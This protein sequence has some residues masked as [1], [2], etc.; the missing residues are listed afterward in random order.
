MSDPIIV[1]G[2]GPV[3]LT[4]AGELARR[5]VPVRIF[6][7]LPAPTTESRAILVHARSLEMFE[8]IGL[9]DEI[10]AAG[11]RTDAMEMHAGKHSTARIELG[12][13]DSSF[14]Y[15]ITIAQTETERI[16]TEALAGHGV[17]V[18]RGMTLTG[19]E[20]DETGVRAT[21]S[22]ADGNSE[23]VA[24]AW[25]VGTDGARSE[26]RRL[27]GS[28][29]AGSF[30]GE[31]FLM[32]DVHAAHDFDQHTMYTFFSP[33]DG[34]LMVFPMKGDRAR[35]IAQIPTTA[36]GSATQEWLQQVADD[37]SGERIK[38]HDS[39]WLTTFEI[40]HAQV[41]QYRYGRVFLAGDAAHIHS[42]AGG[43]GMNT[44]MQDAFNLG[45][46]LAA[47]SSGT[48]GSALLDSYN[49]ER[50]PVGAKVIE[51]ATDLMRIATLSNPV[52]QKVRNGAMHAL[53]VLA[54]VRQAMADKTEETALSYRDSPLVVASTGHAQIASGDH[55]PDT[56]PELRTALAHESGHVLLTVAPEHGVPAIESSA[57]Q[58]LVTTTAIASTQIGYDIALCDLAGAAASRY[59]LPHGGRIMI[60]PDGYIAAIAALD[61]DAPLRAYEALLSA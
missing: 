56:I 10:I 16:L 19:L 8:R 23:E 37:R 34:P 24:G 60:R 54:P 53:T 4:A 29:L 9:V 49:A 47:A 38:I 52:A 26:A 48:A 45:W 27:V 1:V 3:G 13:I 51:F 44:G 32:G 61:D 50:H 22:Y 55:L 6:D 59:G 40:H 12:A 41:P 25:L 15:S 11:V 30:K 57:R 39:L 33:H 21:L 58:I 18:E 35:L 17:S 14:P 43:Q 7:R 5:G 36:E 31:R 42:P 2:A 20:Q 28:A 46:K